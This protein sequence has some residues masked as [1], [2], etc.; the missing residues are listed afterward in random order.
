VHIRKADH[1]SGN[2]LRPLGFPDCVRISFCHYNTE[3]EIAR[4]L[5]AMEEA[6]AET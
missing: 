6:I 5:A 2:V 3:G 4:L 1:F